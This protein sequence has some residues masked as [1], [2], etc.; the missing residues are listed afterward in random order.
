M[1]LGTFKYLPGK[2]SRYQG[3]SSSSSK[4]AGEMITFLGPSAVVWTSTFGLAGSGLLELLELDAGVS[5]FFSCTT[6]LRL[7]F[8]V[9]PSRYMLSSSACAG[10]GA[11]ATPRSR[12]KAAAIL[13]MAAQ[14]TGCACSGAADCCDVMG[15]W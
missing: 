11:V 12:P 3:I 5:S 9:E 10:A 14:P 8:L 4:S 13:A 7:D 15:E 1:S 6:F 2:R